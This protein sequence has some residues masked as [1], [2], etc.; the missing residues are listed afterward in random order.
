MFPWHMMWELHVAPA[1]DSSSGKKVEAK[2]G[3]GEELPEK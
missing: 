2:S 1:E 3:R